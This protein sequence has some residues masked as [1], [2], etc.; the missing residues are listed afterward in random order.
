MKEGKA[1][2]LSEQCRNA[3]QQLLVAA[4]KA[5]GV[6]AVQNSLRSVKKEQ[7]RRDVEKHRRHVKIEKWLPENGTLKWKEALAS[8]KKR[9][10]H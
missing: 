6:Q 3:K 5:D 8:D 4:M 9:E 2:E 7:K 10:R 1:E